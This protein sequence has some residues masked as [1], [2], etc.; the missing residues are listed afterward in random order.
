MVTEVAR[1]EGGWG[2]NA[3]YVAN[4]FAYVP[5][6]G[7]SADYF[8]GCTREDLIRSPLFTSFDDARMSST[9]ALNI[10]DYGLRAKMLGDAIPAE[11][12]AAGA[13]AT[14]GVG[15]NYNMQ[16]DTPNGWP[17][18][19]CDE[20]SAGV[21]MRWL[22][23]DLKNVAFFYVHKLYLKIVGDLGK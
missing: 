21:V 3:R 22:H 15:G 12:F 23:S 1:H 14:E 5:L 20:T 18:D 8:A 19:R 16:C 11:S 2:I 9:N 17:A 4:P 6:V 10:V 7:L 13:N